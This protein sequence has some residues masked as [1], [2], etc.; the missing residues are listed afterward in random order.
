MLWLQ[1]YIQNIAGIPGGHILGI[2]TTTKGQ[3][4]NRA[5]SGDVGAQP[6]CSR[7]FRLGF[8][9]VMSELSLKGKA[10]VSQQEEGWSLEIGEGQ[11]SRQRT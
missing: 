1:R 4:D 6:G 10:E 7:R 11:C 3:G 8:L 5:E 9:E 2:I